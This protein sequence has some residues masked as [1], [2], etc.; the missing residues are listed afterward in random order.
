MVRRSALQDPK[1]DLVR[2]NDEFTVS[3]VLAFCTATAAG[4]TG[5]SVSTAGLLP[6]ITIAL[7]GRA[8][9]AGAM[10][11]RTRDGLIFERRSA[12]KLR[13]ERPSSDRPRL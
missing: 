1:T 2:V 6:D 5:I 3:I 8:A 12:G 10:Y 4:S 13:R 9:L 7:S 11:L